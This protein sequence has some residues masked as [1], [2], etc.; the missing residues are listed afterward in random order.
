[1]STRDHEAGPAPEPTDP[2]ASD[3]PGAGGWSSRRWAQ[4]IDTVV[5]VVLALASMLAAWAGYQAGNWNQA[6]TEATIRAERIQIDATRATTTGYLMMQI[7]LALFINWLNAYQA[8]N[9]DLARFYVERFSPQLET[10]FAAWV[11]TDPLGNPDAPTDP[12][13]MADYYVPQLVQ[14]A[15]LDAEVD[16]A[17]IESA[18]FG[19]IGDAYVLTTLLLAVVL[20][21]GG[22]STKVGWRPAQVAMVILAVVLLLY[23]IQ[24]L[25]ILP[26]GSDWRL[27]PLW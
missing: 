14:A 20:F 4:V 26:D 5:V 13:R 1:M 7:D 10:A 21:F 23:C 15:E 22:I 9:Q 25:A 11:A 18:Q 17:F 8:E 2:A 12:F 24:D 19:A 3:T 6:Q 27:T 16:A